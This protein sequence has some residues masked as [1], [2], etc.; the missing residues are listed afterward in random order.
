MKRKLFIEKQDYISSGSEAEVFKVDDGCYKNFRPRVDPLTRYRK[1]RLLLYLEKLE[2]LKKYYPEIK[3]I[4]DSFLGLYMRGYVMSPID[5]IMLS[6]SFFEVGEV[7]KLLDEL[8]KALD[9]FKKEGLYY[10]DIR[11][12]NIRVKGNSPILL[13]IDSLVFEGTKKLDVLPSDLEP[14][15]YRGGKIDDHAQIVMFNNFTLEALKNSDR[16]LEHD[17]M[18]WEIMACK[19]MGKI[20]DSAWDHEYYYEHIKKKTL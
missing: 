17:E 11:E 12:P 9:L 4:V 1:R 13:D 3:Y 6:T 14:Y 7:I 19:E 15:L 10:F 18:A 5:K 20:H 16:N 8:R 2:C